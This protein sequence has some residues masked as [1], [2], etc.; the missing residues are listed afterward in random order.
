VLFANVS[1]SRVPGVERFELEGAERPVPDQCL[2]PGERGADALDVA[3]AWRRKK[4]ALSRSTN[5]HSK[6]GAV[7]SARLQ[8]RQNENPAR[9]PKGGVSGTLMQG[10]CGL[11]E[12]SMRKTHERARGSS[13]NVRHKQPVGHSLLKI[14]DHPC[15]AAGDRDCQR[16]AC[17]GAVPAHPAGV[18]LPLK[19]QL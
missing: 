4:L 15:F 6:C 9:I 5:R 1:A 12:G 17:S 3:R 13:R 14:P 18:T 2:D 10:V 11:L 19:P 7:F 16:L 8:R